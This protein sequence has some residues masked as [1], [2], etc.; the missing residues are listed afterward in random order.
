MKVLVTGGTGFTGSA[1]VMRLLDMG[2]HVRSLDYQEGIRC[3]ELRE[4]GAEIIIG[5]IE[6]RA[7]VNRSV[8]GMEVV[9]HVAAAFREL[10]VPDKHYYEVNVGGTRNVMEAAKNYGVKKV[11]YCSTQGVHGHI[12]T[13]PGDENSPIKPEDYY[14]QTKYEGELVVQEFIK[15][16]MNA[17]IIRPTAI[18]GPGDPERFFMIFKRVKN[19]TFPIFGSGKTYYH[20]VYI[21]NLIDAFILVM[22]L[23]RGKGETYIIA[24][25]D[26]LPIKILVEKVGKAL[27]VPVKIKHYPLL[28][29]MIAGHICEKV[30]KPFG[31]AP[32]IFPRRVDW[33]RQV[34]AYKIDKAK[35]DLGYQP[36]V[37][38]E[39]GLRRTGEWYK[40]NGY[41]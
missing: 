21:D 8:E 39:E 28:P 20:P 11:V 34:R 1:L 2:H 18:Y 6:D 10:D 41:L 9:Y 38:I 4:A 35:R 13:P 37:C 29:L 23:D 33:Y 3:T 5:S 36:H 31:I 7:L 22:D 15:S 14:Q 40:D 19:G 17:T 16:G 25:D 12:T 30:C 32:P 27:G 26:Y 24:D